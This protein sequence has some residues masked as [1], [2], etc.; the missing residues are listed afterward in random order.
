MVVGFVN[1]VYIVFWLFVVVG[2]VDLYVM[3]Q[4]LLLLYVVKDFIFCLLVSDE[5]GQFFGG[6]WLVQ[7]NVLQCGQVLK[8]GVRLLFGVYSKFVYWYCNWCCGGFFEKLWVKCD[9]VVGVCQSGFQFQQLCQLCWCQC[10]E[11]W[12]VIGKNGNGVVS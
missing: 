3:C 11:C 5:S 7:G 2:V 1:V 6:N 8:I 9:V 10:I 12:C 4:F